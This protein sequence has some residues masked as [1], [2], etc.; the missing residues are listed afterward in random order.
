MKAF[1]LFFILSPCFA[2]SDKRAT[3][4]A[5]E[6]YHKLHE[7]SDTINTNQK[8]LIGQQYAFSE[9]RGW[10][11]HNQHVGT[12]LVSDMQK[13]V[14]VTPA[15]LGV[16]FNEIGNWNNRL[17]MEQMREV[18]RRGGV[19]TMTWHTPAWVQDGKGNG[20]S[21][22]KTMPILPRILPG[23]DHHNILLSEL[24]R[25][26]DFF[27][28]LSDI[29]IIFRPWH[30]QNGSWFWWGRKNC[31]KE[32]YLKLWEITVKVL[33]NRG[34]HNLLF[35]YSPTGVEEDYLERYPGDH[36]I[37]ILGVDHYFYNKV[38]DLVIIGGLSPLQKYKK[39]IVWLCEEAARRN[40]VPAVTEFGME[41][42]SYRRFWTDYF[43]W[44]L[45]RAGMEQIRGV[46]KAPKKGPAYAML[47]RNDMTDKKHYYGPIPGH[48]NN[49][50]FLD[51]M[52][53]GIFQGM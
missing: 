2:Q 5:K 13:A 17:L 16:D 43:G 34:V 23:G 10:R 46:G 21:W 12:E 31:T 53:K 22:D 30:E 26:A 6:L 51:L 4:E 38:F 8:I 7:V 50:N 1:I 9:G 41:T 47:W 28:E 3:S 37:D 18:H 11:K 20:S 14:G 40:K 29:P 39:G 25:L 49:Q 27:L 33:R 42:S 32:E 52:S 35:A 48:K 44:P 24:N 19:V 15:V 36:V 45:E